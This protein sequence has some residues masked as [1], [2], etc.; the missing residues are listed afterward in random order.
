MTH[1]SLYT[2]GGCTFEISGSPLTEAV[3]ALP[4]FAPFRSSQPSPVTFRIGYC[5]DDVHPAP[6]RTMHTFSA[7]GVTTIFSA[8]AEG[9]LLQ[10]RHVA[11]HELALWCDTDRQIFC[12]KGDTV[13][14]L[15]RFALWIAYGLGTLACRRIALHSSCIV[16][17][18]QAFL[19]LGE[20]GTGKS[21]HTRLWQEHIPGSF[22][23]NDDSPVISAGT[24]GIWVYGS[25]WSGK[26][27]CYRTECYPLGG[28]I[29]LSQ[30]RE[31]RM[32]RLPVIQAYA[33]LHPSCPPQF[34]Y[35][36]TL[37]DGISD[38]LDNLL[39]QIPVYHLACLPDAEATQLSYLYLS[40]SGF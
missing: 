34:A 40:S 15:L 17:D 30:A 27:P 14:V 36:E 10:M 39:S 4:G 8:S 12:F 28:C 3:D 38:I 18:G 32:R 5:A 6:V 19:F 22:L 9:Y 35:D 33:A 24:D 11:G 26:T 13:P 29:R 25:P 31:N 7:E 21:T 16:K 1:K 2:I 20:S 23:L 37:Y